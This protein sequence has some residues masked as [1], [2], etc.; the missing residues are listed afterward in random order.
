M[1]IDLYQMNTFSTWRD[2]FSISKLTLWKRK[3]IIKSLLA[4]LK[5]LNNCSESSSEFLFLLSLLSLVNFHQRTC[6]SWLPEQFSESQ[7]AF[8]I[9]SKV[10]GGYLQAG[11][12]FLKRVT[13]KIFRISKWFQRSKQKTLFFIFSSKKA[14]KYSKSQQRWY[15]MYWFD[16]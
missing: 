5:T 3:I 11:I 9:T 16:F 12:S 6:H 1:N 2:G 14:A 10:T 15:K 8:G 4:S 7:V 13:V